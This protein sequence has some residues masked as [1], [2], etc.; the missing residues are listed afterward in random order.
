MD[1]A[2][3][4]LHVILARKAPVG[5]IFRRGPSSW[6]HLVKWNTDTDTFEHGQWFHGQIDP[7]RSDLSPNGELIVYFCATWSKG[8]EAERMIEKKRAG[9][10]THNLDRLLKHK[11][12]VRTEYTYAWTAVSKPPF[13]TAVGL[14]P[15]RGLLARGRIVQVESSFVAEPP[16]AYGQPS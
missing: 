13:L 12:K 2:A 16:T 3:A 10:S 6:V 14:W 5:V 8:E 1:K 4:R 7:R 9:D 11:L 15:K